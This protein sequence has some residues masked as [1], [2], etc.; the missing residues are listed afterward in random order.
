M[1]EYV[2]NQ[3][4]VRQENKDATSPIADKVHAKSESD[5]YGKVVKNAIESA[6][7]KKNE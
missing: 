6:K 1:Q 7:K 3:K 5:L 2:K 4:Q